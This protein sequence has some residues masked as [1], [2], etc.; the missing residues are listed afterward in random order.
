M[1]DRMINVFSFKFTLQPYP[2]ETQLRLGKVCEVYLENTGE[3]T[4]R[5]RANCYGS[6]PY[7]FHIFL[8]RVST[9]VHLSY[10][11]GGQRIVLT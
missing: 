6:R 11:K 9:S 5:F 10:K 2:K 1:D 8:P 3:I 4:S 7:K